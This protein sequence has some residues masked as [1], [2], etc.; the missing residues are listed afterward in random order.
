M[1]IAHSNQ[2]KTTRLKRRVFV[3]NKILNSPDTALDDSIRRQVFTSLLS[4]GSASN[5]NPSMNRGANQK[6]TI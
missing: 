1:G 4:L 6:E 2:R 3:C 5:F